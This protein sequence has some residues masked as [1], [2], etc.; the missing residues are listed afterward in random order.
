L[1]RRATTALSFL[2]L[3][4]RGVDITSLFEGTSSGPIYYTN[5]LVRRNR[6]FLLLRVMA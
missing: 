4:L 2:R 5:S 3:D 6:P 1:N